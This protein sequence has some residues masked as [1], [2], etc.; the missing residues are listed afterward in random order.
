MKRKPRTTSKPLNFDGAHQFGREIM[1][2]TPATEK[3]YRRLK[4]G[5]CLGCGKEKCKCKRKS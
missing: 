5:Q 3:L 1:V 2:E 4:N